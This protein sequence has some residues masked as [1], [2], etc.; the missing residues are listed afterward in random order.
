MKHLFWCCFAI[1]SLLACYGA[2]QSS[3]QIIAR[4]IGKDTASA[5]KDAL[6]Q[7]VQQA[8]GALVDSETLIK[9]DEIV[10]E[11]ILTF[12]DGFVTKYEVLKQKD[13][14]LGFVEVTIKAQVEQKK[15]REKLGSTNILRI[16]VD[17]AQHVWAQIETENLRRENAE[18]ILM[19][20]FS[21]L[22][23]L[24]YL[25]PVLVD[26]TGKM[27]A[28]AKLNVI[29][30]HDGNVQISMGVCL[31]FNHAKF[32]KETLPHLEMI[33]DK[34]CIEKSE[35][36]YSVNEHNNYSRL[37]FSIDE[38]GI[39]SKGG[40]DEK[41]F[42]GKTYNRTGIEFRTKEHE[43]LGIALNISRRYNPSNQKFVCY[44]FPFSEKLDKF[45]REREYDN[46]RYLRA[47]FRLKDAD[48]EEI[49]TKQIRL[50][51]HGANSFMINPLLFEQPGMYRLL[52][53]SPEFLLSQHLFPFSNM[54]LFDF[55]FQIPATDYRDVKSM[56][57]FLEMP[58]E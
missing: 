42:V 57:L 1:C 6:A 11:Q 40:F 46:I 31:L 56:E 7:A 23:P 14:A 13:N 43:S 22:K 12:S 20:T 26:P 50:H 15:L 21:L 32:V 25:T 18:Q 38:K 5:T 24:D 9:N 54:D 8:V 41:F 44:S 36:F 29:D 4:G 2:E 51:F 35:P 34:I 52:M 33:F 3:F 55:S 19:K 39:M 53:I 16:E 58:K 27:G 30:L 37:G 10:S 48:G 47:V 17:D 45:L 28:E 49:Y